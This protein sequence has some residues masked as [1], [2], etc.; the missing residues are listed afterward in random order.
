MRTPFFEEQTVLRRVLIANRGEVALRIARTAAE[1]GLESVAV[2]PTDDA[3]SLHVRRADQARLLP[4]HGVRAYLDAEALVRAALDSG[5]DAVHPGYGFLAENAAF[6]RLCEQAGLRFVGPTPEQIDLFGDKLRARELARECGVPTVA[7]SGDLADAAAAAAFHASL[8]PGAAMILKAVA[9]GGGRG[10]RVVRAGEDPAAVFDQ[11]RAEAKAAFGDDRLY[12]ELYLETARHVEVQ[13]VGD[14]SGA[15]VH[16]R[17]RDCSLQRRHQKIVELAPAPNLP[18]ALLE[19]MLDAAVRMARA[20]AYRSLGTLE[21]L[22][23]PVNDAFYFMEANPRLQVEHTVTE[24]VLGL[25]LVALQF[26]IA[27]GRSLAELDLLAPPQPRGLAVQ[28]RIN[29]ETLAADGSAL[30]SSGTI[31]RYEPATGPGVRVDGAASTGSRIHPAFDSLLAKLVVHVRSDDLGALLRRAERAAGEFVV[32][33][34]RTNLPVLRALLRRPELADYQVTTRF[35]EQHAAELVA[36]AEALAEPAAETATDTASAAPAVQAPPG[37]V[38]VAAPV[39][40]AVVGFE[41]EAGARVR[42]GQTVVVIEAMKMQYTVAAPASGTVRLLAAEPHSVV[43]EGAPLLFLEPEAD[44]GAE[45]AAEERIDLDAIRPDLAEVRARHAI[46][47]DENRPEAVAKRRKTGQRTAR[48]NVEDLCDPGSFIEYGA[49]A[50]AAQRRRRSLEDLIKSTPADGLV[51]GFGTVNAAEYGS[52]RARCAVLAYDYTVLAGTQ[53]FM[54][55]KKT[56]RLLEI[57]AERRLPVVFFTEGGGGRPGDVDVADTHICTLDVPT[58]T[59]WAQMSG[60]APRIAITSGR[61]FAGNAVLFGLS[62]ITIATANANI[63]LAGP[64]MIEGGGLGRFQPEEIG[65]AAELAANGVIDLL[66]EDE[67]QA[68]AATKQLLGYFQGPIRDWRCDDQRKLRHLVPENRLRAYDMRAVI[69]TLA[70]AGSV[71]ELRRDYGPGLITAFVRIEGQPFG[72]IANNPYHL[73]GAIDSPAGEKGARFL[74]LCEAYGLPVISLCDTPG[75]MVGPDSERT[76][77]VRRG[78]RLMMVSAN[79]TVPLFVIALRKGYGLGAQAMAGGGFHRPVLTASWPT[80]EFG[81]MGLEGAVQL[82]FRREL[83]AIADPVERQ[84]RY[85]QLVAKLYEQG[86]AISVASVL[87]VDAV[88][89][90]AETRGW[91]MRGL[92]A[93][94]PVRPG[95]RRYVDVW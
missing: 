84:A 32:Q 52:E 61:C 14:G 49:L 81:P 58:F 65:P 35:V 71:L 55:H 31:Q 95:Q 51:A 19:R 34:V 59:T 42:R 44:D 10:S 50:I 6:A 8:P 63:G 73:G 25:D 82:G 92:T 16:L 24:A 27:A 68:V 80:G 39:N 72:L 36:A 45:T 38:A 12:A 4:G 78:S 46:G 11:C 69:H 57:A 60:L 66:V 1:L 74:Q 87:E 23:D 86:K 30:P 40:G 79:L 3:D 9:G 89:D 85:Q 20:T 15:A 28:L 67:A 94:G 18:P 13:I 91:I 7:G 76:A 90:P 47:L 21:F 29:A 2:H 37:T 41:V 54:N 43:A 5:C 88:I 77:A 53:G 62:D 75:Y 83:E 33:G 93:A 48:E 22:V 56:D 26:A 64:A 70:D 17:E